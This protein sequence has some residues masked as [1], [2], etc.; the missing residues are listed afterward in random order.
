MARGLTNVAIGIAG[1]EPFKDYRGLPDT[2]GRILKVT[3]LAVAWTNWRRRSWSWA[4][5]TGCRWR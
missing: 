5:W 3:T 1:M 4:S 2:E